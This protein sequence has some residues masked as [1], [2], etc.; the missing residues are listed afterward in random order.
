MKGA[1]LVA[2]AAVAVGQSAG[3]RLAAALRDPRPLTPAQIAATMSASRAAFAGKAFRWTTDLDDANGRAGATEVLVGADGRPRFLRMN[4]AYEAGFVGGITGRGEPTVTHRQVEARIVIEFTRQRARACG[5]SQSAGELIVEYRNDGGGWT[6][7]ALPAPHPGF[8][9]GVF[10]ILGGTLPVSSGSLAEIGNRR[11]RAFVGAWT[12]LHG[13]SAE[14]PL[15]IGDPLPNVRRQLSPVT[16]SQTLWIDVESLLPLRWE[17][18]GG[19]Q[20]SFGYD[21]TLTIAAPAGV[22]PPDCVP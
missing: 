12:P 17:T 4:L 10:E 22:T 20:Y 13:P 18:S 7:A 11:G 19:H 21:P 16:P 14:P 2:A 5:S 8:P 3:A 6:A 1:L 15:I 9:A